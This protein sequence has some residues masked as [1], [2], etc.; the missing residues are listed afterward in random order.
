MGGKKVSEGEEQPCYAQV[1]YTKY[2]PSLYVVGDLFPGVAGWLAG[3][4]MGLLCDGGK[5]RRRSYTAQVRHL[6]RALDY[7]SP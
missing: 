6:I 3:P 2:A 4:P 7:E 1:L 5:K